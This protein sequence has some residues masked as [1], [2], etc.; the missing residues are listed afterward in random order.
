MIVHHVAKIGRGYVWKTSRRWHFLYKT[1]TVITLFPM[2]NLPN[3]APSSRCAE[4]LQFHHTWRRLP[5]WGSRSRYAPQSDGDKVHRVYNNGFWGISNLL[6]YI[7]LAWQA[8]IRPIEELWQN[9]YYTSRKHLG[10]LTY[11]GQI[12][13]L[14][15]FLECC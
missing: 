9:I 15:G 6:N 14:S 8:I 3:L 12:E 11:S 5:S 13:N 10:F 4:K 7:T 1:L 2:I